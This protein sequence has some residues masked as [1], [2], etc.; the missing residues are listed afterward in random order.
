V[1]HSL[2]Q[3]IAQLE[4]ENELIRIKEF[5]DPKL[6]ITEITDRIS[7]H[8]G[9]ALLFENTGTAFPLLINAYGSEKRIGMALRVNHLDDIAAEIEGLFK[10]LM[11]PKDNIL[12]K[13]KL[14]PQLGA[15]A[16]WM[17]KIS[18]ARGL[19]ASCYG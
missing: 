13:L 11:K 2:N 9:K 10:M 6:E 1:Y 7:K 14:L 17:P 18:K 12:D 5:V 16:S 15:M 3:F 19:S 4:K 8:N